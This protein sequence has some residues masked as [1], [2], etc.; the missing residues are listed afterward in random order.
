M[1][2]IQFVNIPTIK[3]VQVSDASTLMLSSPIGLRLVLNWIVALHTESWLTEL[4]LDGALWVMRMPSVEKTFMLGV[5]NEYTSPFADISACKIT[6]LQQLV[7][8][9]EVR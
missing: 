6:H 7:C 1:R 3:R 4:K 8:L 2:Y 9:L 5:A